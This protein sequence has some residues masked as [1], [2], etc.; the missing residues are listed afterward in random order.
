MNNRMLSPELIDDAKK[1]FILG[2][3][4]RVAAYSFASSG[5]CH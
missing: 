3:K 2:L 1:I 4:Q 5:I